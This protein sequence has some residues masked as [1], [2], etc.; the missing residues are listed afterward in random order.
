MVGNG[1]TGTV[2]P[3]QM[4]DTTIMQET[5]TEK[6]DKKMFG[7]TPRTAADRRPHLS[8]CSAFVDHIPA[9]E[10]PA[11][12]PILSGENDIDILNTA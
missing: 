7:D 11:T 9:P 4:H 10:F 8:C 5:T 3:G 2:P 6:H 12:V 1:V